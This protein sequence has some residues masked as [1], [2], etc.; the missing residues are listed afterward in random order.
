M[1]SSKSSE[2]N[3]IDADIADLELK[4]Q[5]SSAKKEKKQQTKKAKTS[6]SANTTDAKSDGLLEK[7]KFAVGAIMQN[8]SHLVFVGLS[9]AIYFY[10]EYASI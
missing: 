6:S 4:I 8:S 3:Q 7:G 9:T 1:I 10:G 2:L 5:S